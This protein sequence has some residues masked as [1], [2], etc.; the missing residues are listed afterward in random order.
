MKRAV[1]VGGGGGGDAAAFALRKRGF[2]GEVVVLSADRDRPYDRPY[3]SKE[4]LRGE[5]ELAKV[6]LHEEADYTREKVDLRLQQKVAGGSLADRRVLLEDGGEIEFDVLVIAT[7]G[8]PRRLPDAP[9]AYNVLTLRSLRDSQTLRDALQRSSRLLLVGAGFI[10]AEVAASARMLGKDVLMVESAAVPL[11]RALGAEVGE[12]Y[13]GIHR[14]KGVDLRTGATVKEWHT[15]GGRVVGVT[16]ADGTKEDIDLALVAIG[17]DPNVQL[18]RTFGLPVEGSGVRV[19]EGL[20]AADGVYCAGDIALHAHPVLG[21]A[22]RVEHWEV[23]KNQGRGVAA[24][25]AG[26]HVPYTRLPYFWS[27]QYDV[28]LEYRGHAAGDDQA[29]W[30][31]DRAGLRFSVFYLREGRVNA[32]LSMND[33]ETNEVGGKLIE[34]RRVVDPGAL[35]DESVDLAGLVAAPT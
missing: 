33:K 10:G 27:D 11:A 9:S 12:V 32:V 8:T 7:G 4:F 6:F 17:I 15:Y 19:D 34:G 22:I 35:A 16:V 1:I 25:I 13:A 20:R 23:A 24:S 26:G 18:P 28:S 21:R 3:L 2:D 5:V 31:G 29:I 30:R 14:A